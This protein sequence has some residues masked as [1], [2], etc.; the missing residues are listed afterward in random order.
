MRETIE[1]KI[2][3]KVTNIIYRFTLIL[4][5]SNMEGEQFLAQNR[6]E[7]WYPLDNAAKIYPAITTDEVT[8]V[9]RITANLKKKVNIKMLFIAVRSIESRFPYYKVHVKKGF[10]WYYFESANFLTSIETDSKTPCRRF[11]TRGHLFRILVGDNKLSVEFSHLLTDGGGAFEY[12][13][14]LLVHYFELTGVEIPADFKHLKVDEAPIPEEFEDAYNRYFQEDVPALAKRPRAFHL[15]F[16]LSSKP[17][18]NVLYAMVASSE[19]KAKAK[20]RGVSITEYLTAIYFSVLQDVWESLPKH[21]KHRRHKKLAIEVPI[22]L[23]KLYPSQ[24]MR[25]FTL[26]VIPEIDLSLGHYTFEEIVKTVY[27]QMQLE[28]DKKLVNKILALNVGGERNILVRGIP[29]LLK[30]IFMRYLYYAMGS[31]QYSGTLTNM[32][33]VQLPQQMTDQID[34]FLLTPPPPNKLIKMGCGIISM[35]DKLVISFCGIVKTKEFEKR[36]I[37]FL[38]KEGIHVKITTNK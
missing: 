21:S 20:E 14:T 31:T 4:K 30:S 3:P 33:A 19:I 13:K 26:F 15:P 12:F 7:F 16:A 18:F 29:L 36:Y 32:G 34:C 5:A 38:V 9:F 27:H 35:N 6:N 23:R 10:F 37:D 11:R 1:L 17:R 22:N 28:T 8:S 24:T 2:L 25:N